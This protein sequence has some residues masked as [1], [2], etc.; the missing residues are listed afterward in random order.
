MKIGVLTS[1][2]ADFG[3][4]SSLLDQLV[5]ESQFDMHIIAFG[6]HLSQGHGYTVTEIESKG[7]KNIHQVETLVLDTDPRAISQSY[8]DVT[9][10]FSE[11]W[12]QEQ[13]DLVLTLG[14]RYEMNAAVQASIPYRVKLA[15]FHGG[16][17]TLGAID[18]IY[19]HQI[20][21]A[22]EIH[23]TAANAFSERL[24]HLLDD[25]RNIFYVGSMSIVDLPE[26]PEISETQ[27]RSKYNL[28]DR[29]FILA[30]FHPETDEHNSNVA[31]AVE[32]KRTL[33][34]IPEAFDII[35]TMPNADT[36]GTLYRNALQ[37]T[38]EA[39][40]DRLLLIESF[41]KANYFA[42]LTYCDFVL[43][44]S[45]SGIIEAASFNKFVINVGDRQKGRLRSGNV[46]DVPFSSSEILTAINNLLQRSR[47]FSGKNEYA[48][49]N[50]VQE[51]IEVLRKFGNGEI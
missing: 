22:S 11:F 29:P 12:S 18:N 39:L 10:K 38:K 35:V 47:N 48:K 5:N 33:K 37:E 32:M 7:F 30:T 14:D 23:F 45:S 49:E 34:Q 50:T 15:H 40:G 6:T 3:I 41:G 2:R 28:S 24:K 13:F 36:N 16:E 4:Y 44:N 8:A 25:S 9:T 17:K 51:V 19:R 21:L 31:Y 20:S 43:G 42:A 46:I 26:A 1:S 27:F